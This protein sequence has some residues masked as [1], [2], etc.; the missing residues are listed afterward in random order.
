[1]I[2]ALRAEWTKLRTLAGTAWLLGGAVVVTVAVSA[3]IAATTHV[4]SDRGQ[5][6]TK[7]ALTGITLGQAVVAVL[8]V[9]A[10]SDEYGTG[11]IRLTLTAMPRRVVVLAAKAATVAGLA[12]LTGL[13]AVAGCLLVGR[14]MLPGA[15]LDPAHGYALISI[16]HG[17][18]LRA[19]ACGGLYVMLVALLALGVATAVRDTAVSIGAVLALLYLPPILAQAVTGTLRRHLEQVAPMTAGLAGQATTNLGSLPIAPWPGVGVLGAWAAA[20]L[21]LAGLLLRHRDA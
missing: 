7:L 6:P 4:T 14:L 1:M 8:A 13:L 11:M 17:P 15:G 21:L 18:T 10:V 3:G 12:L 9:L 2:D 19:A 5:D 16:R 20:A